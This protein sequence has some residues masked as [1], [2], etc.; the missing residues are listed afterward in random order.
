MGRTLNLAT[1]LVGQLERDI[2]TGALQP[3]DKLDERTLS[4]R[5][6]VSRTPVREALQKLASSGLVETRP[7]RGTVVASIT[8]NELIEMFEVMSELESYCARLAARRMMAQEVDAL[9][10]LHEDCQ[11]ETERGEADPYYAA[12]VAFHEAIYA[13]AH[14]AYLARQTQAV[15]NRLSPYRRLQLYRPGRISGS[16]A[17]HA[18][19]LDAIARHDPEAAGAVMLRHVDIQGAA[20]NDLLAILPRAYLSGAKAG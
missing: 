13:G 2:V 15:R 12:N 5:F 4:E 1:T 17:E 18:E 10:R 9:R 11:R 7:R 19:V 16:C 3:G 14:N 8:I 6:H 20:L